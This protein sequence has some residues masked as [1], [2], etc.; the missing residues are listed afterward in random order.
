MHKLKRSFGVLILTTQDNLFSFVN[1]LTH[2]QHGVLFAAGVSHDT[3]FV[4]KE[5]SQWRAVLIDYLF[6]FFIPL[7]SYSG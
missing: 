1:F 3:C 5:K 7:F 4:E 6:T 2:L